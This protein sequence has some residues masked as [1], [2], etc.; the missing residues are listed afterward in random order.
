[1]IVLENILRN[2]SRPFLDVTFPCA[3]K[4]PFSLRRHRKSWSF[5][6]PIFGFPYI[7][8]PF[9]TSSQSFQ[10][11][12]KSDYSHVNWDVIEKRFEEEQKCLLV[13]GRNQ[14][15]SY[16]SKYLAAMWFM[17]Q[18]Q[19]QSFQNATFCSENILNNPILST[20]AIFTTG[21][22]NIWR[23]FCLQ[24]S[25]IL[26]WNSNAC[27]CSANIREKEGKKKSFEMD[28]FLE[29]QEIHFKYSSKNADEE[30]KKFGFEP[31]FENVDCRKFKKWRKIFIF[32]DFSSQ[33]VCFL[34]SSIN[35]A[36]HVTITND[37]SCA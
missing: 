35:S 22:L 17:L 32:E 25:P 24:K 29:Y 6:S 13:V 21:F 14:K 19:K 15:L 8:S 2:A 3:F 12:Q 27:V 36:S 11:C 16:L 33:I 23:I 5:A 10:D 9:C 1:M 34:P 7:F 28:T 26:I 31:K 18:R 20:N 4:I 37:G 30:K